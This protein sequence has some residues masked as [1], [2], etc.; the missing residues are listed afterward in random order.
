MRPR[1]N[2]AMT[3]AI[4]EELFLVFLRHTKEEAFAFR[5]AVDFSCELQQI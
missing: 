3:K 2:A 1:S 5:N 4:V